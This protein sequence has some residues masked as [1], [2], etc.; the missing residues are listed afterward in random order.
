M[1]LQRSILNNINMF[2]IIPSA[3]MKYMTLR[4]WDIYACP[5]LF[6]SWL[7]DYLELNKVAPKW[8]GNK[9]V[10][11][12]S[13]GECHTRLFLTKKFEKKYLTFNPKFDW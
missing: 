11:V 1:F 9:N 2:S 5:T 4:W 10:P 7:F 3:N 13:A 6:L 8:L 12:F